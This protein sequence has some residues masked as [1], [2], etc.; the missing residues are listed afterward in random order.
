[1]IC[2]LIIIVQSEYK[3]AQDADEA[4]ATL[5][6]I[7]KIDHVVAALQRERGLTTAYLSSE[8][9]HLSQ[10]LEQQRAETDATLA[11][12]WPGEPNAIPNEASA[13]K[14]K[15]TA[16]PAQDLQQEIA[17]LRT[18]VVE[19]T[20]SERE[21]FDRYTALLM[22]LARRQ[23]QEADE[24]VFR[25][26]ALEQA[27]EF[28]RMVAEYAGRERA[29]GAAALAR[30]AATREDYERILLLSGKQN[31]LLEELKSSPVLEVRTLADAITTAP[32]VTELKALRAQLLAGD[33]ESFGPGE[34]FNTAARKVDRI[35][36]AHTR[37]MQLLE[38]EAKL[39]SQRQGDTLIWTI[40]MA[41]AAILISLGLTYYFCSKL[42]YLLVRLTRGV[43]RM[44]R[45]QS[46]IWVF[47]GDRNDIIGLMA[48]SIASITRQGEENTRIRAA[49]AISDAQIMILDPEGGLIFINGALESS[50][51][52]SMDYFFEVLPDLDPFAM[53]DHTIGLVKGA[54][55]QN[56]TTLEALEDKTRVEVSFGERLFEVTV[57]PVRDVGGAQVGYTVEWR[58]V[59]ETRAVE[60]QIEELLE[61]TKQGDF[62]RRLEVSSSQKFL[63]SVADGMNMISEQ[64][65]SFI[66]DL[67]IALGA[68]AEGDLTRRVETA[69]AGDLGD[70]TASANGT[71]QRLNALV[72]D[73]TQNG[74]QIQDNSDMIRD[75]A[76]QLATKTEESAAALEETAAAMEEMS[77][78]IATV[79]NYATDAASSANEATQ[80]A[81]RGGA[82]VEDAV[83][84][85]ARIRDHSVKISDFVGVIDGIAFQTNLLALNAAVEAARAGEAG[86][87]FAVVASEVRALAQ[88]SAEAAR[89]VNEIM[90]LSTESVEEGVRQVEATG[91]ALREIVA[92]S[93][94]VNDKI[95]MIS[96]VAQ[97][98]SINVREIAA[99]VANLDNVTQDTA[100]VA[101]VNANHSR[102]LATRAEALGAM[103]TQFTT[104]ESQKPD[105]AAAQSPEETI[106]A[107]GMADD[108]LA[109][110]DINAGDI[111]TDD[112]AAFNEDA[113]DDAFENG[114]DESF[115]GADENSRIA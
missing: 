96:R 28:T 100:Q 95:A 14:V 72:S 111:N 2:A 101:E 17:T 85:M 106:E 40:S 43:Q 20:I 19:R 27:D 48:R 99:T 10:E 26:K 42:T 37:V 74:V 55:E 15:A 54:L 84:A 115:E 90:S 49:L 102:Q 18:A 62:S 35:S 91:K 46:D 45:G 22:P 56:G 75:G 109:A 110:N 104:D 65:S 81:S 61:A 66:A 79:A 47:G 6:S 33:T 88:R 64:V 7:E 80:S 50:L 103:V 16:S 38:E 59:T 71:T 31:A 67:K 39:I 13:D 112:M 36:A 52:E 92:A 51:E 82:V 77:S 9:D 86:K 78:G 68:L 21:A 73:I 98:Q 89:G 24:G 114:G 4:V 29:V 12:N 30:P 69:Y 57:A 1:M 25:I 83:T 8:V 87:G 107:L 94:A 5:R 76:L 3:V 44:S 23:L 97:D 60:I 58:E 53:Y 11:K 105:N 34:W 93:S 32:E 41:V 70:L 113:L 63:G 108:G